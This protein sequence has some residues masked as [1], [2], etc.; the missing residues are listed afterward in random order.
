MC[1]GDSST[2]EDCTGIVNGDVVTDGCG[3]CGGDSST[4]EE[5]CAGVL[6]GDSAEDACGVCGGDTSSCTY[7][8]PCSE[9]RSMCVVQSASDV[10]LATSDF[11]SCDNCAMAE[12]ADTGMF[13]G[14]ADC[15]NAGICSA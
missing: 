2:C 4:C 9:D 11:A 6:N 12:Q 3:V 8:L 14:G 1:N 7:A 15:L 5:D 10:G 13:N